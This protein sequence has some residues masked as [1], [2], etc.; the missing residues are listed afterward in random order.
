MAFEQ[1]TDTSDIVAG[2]DIG[3]NIAPPGLKS[4]RLQ[5]VYRILYKI[6][7]LFVFFSQQCLFKTL[8]G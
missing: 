1:I 8:H 2:R 3:V 4:V 6:P 5:A 7:D